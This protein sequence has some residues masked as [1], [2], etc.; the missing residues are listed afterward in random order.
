MATR[1]GGT[2]DELPAGLLEELLSL[3][4]NFRDALSR[5]GR[6]LVSDD[7]E[8]KALDRRIGG[9]LVREARKPLDERGIRMAALAL[10]MYRFFPEL[11]FWKERQ[12][13][14]AEKAAV[15][16]LVRS[17]ARRLESPGSGSRRAVV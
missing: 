13:R 10:G 17:S 9:I 8:L 7:A 11:K 6:G 5:A 12:L 16:R 2:A 1:A 4:E 14:N 15:E 3:K